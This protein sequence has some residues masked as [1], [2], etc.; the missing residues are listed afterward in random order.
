M[1]PLF[2]RPIPHDAPGVLVDNL[3][4]LVPDEIMDI[5]IEQMEGR[6]RLSDEFFTPPRPSPEAGEF[7]RTCRQP[8]LADRHQPNAPSPSVNLEIV[9]ASQRLRD[10]Q[11]G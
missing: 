9:S 2:P 8:G 10:H 7:L 4:L 5:A 11:R 1:Q 3:D 6:E